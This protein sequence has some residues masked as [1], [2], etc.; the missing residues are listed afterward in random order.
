MQQ[1][2]GQGESQP[3]AA[4]QSQPAQ[5]PA[6]S[7]K[8]DKKGNEAPQVASKYAKLMNDMNQ[9]KGNI[10]F[11][12]E[13]IDQSEPGEVNETLKDMHRALKKVE[14]KVQGVITQ[15]E[16]EALVHA[17]IIIND[18]IQKTFKRIKQIQK[19]HKPEIFKPG[20]SM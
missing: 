8:S 16:D 9:V 4:R 14:P 7:N 5:K 10:N 18:D 6:A 2:S 13:V 19:G 12:N 1:Q 17:C 15:V 3:S 20:E 11:T